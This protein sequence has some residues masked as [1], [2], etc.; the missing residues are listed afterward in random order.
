MNLPF[1]LRYYQL[2]W[3]GCSCSNAVAEYCLLQC[4][5]A[6]SSAAYGILL[7]RC[8]LYSFCLGVEAK[9]YMISAVCASGRRPLS[10]KESVGK[11]RHW[12]AEESS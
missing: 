7:L 9:A 10:H 2:P 5:S 6:T 11:R 3:M 8:F 4:V 1:L 12:C